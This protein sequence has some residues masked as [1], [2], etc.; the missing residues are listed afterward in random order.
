MSEVTSLRRNQQEE[1]QELQS[2]HARKKKKLIQSEEA[3]L[4]ELKDNYQQ[5]KEN[6]QTQGQAAV[7]HIRRGEEVQV[8]NLKEYYQ[9]R[10]EFTQNEGQAAVNHIKKN[11]DEEYQ[12][13]MANKEKIIQHTNTKMNEIEANY[14]KKLQDATAGREEKIN[15]VRIKV[16]KEIQESEEK[17]QKKLE[18]YRT[19]SVQEMAQKKEAYRNQS[20]Q[21]QQKAQ[22][23]LQNLDEQN[24]KAVQRELSQGK[25]AEEQARLVNEKNLTEITTTGEKEIQEEKKLLEDKQ[26]RLVSEFSQKQDKISKQWHQ[27]EINLNSEYANRIT[28]NKKANEEQIKKQYEHFKSTYGKNQKAQETSLQIQERNY[29][30]NLNEQKKDFLKASAKYNGKEEDPFY[31]VQD[32]G[33]RIFEDSGSYFIEAYLPEH[34]KDNVKIVVQKDKATVQGQR[35]FKDTFD[36][37]GKKVSTNSYQTFREE[38]SFDQPVITDGMTRE[39]DGDWVRISIPKMLNFEKKLDKKG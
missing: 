17:N 20:A 32:R 24:Q 15:Q 37:G 6:A 33:S 21:Y 27:R 16:N 18:T 10:K 7:N 19:E 22:K 3:K 26:K 4:D 31:K 25:K 13:A 39:R 29:V 12:K 30:K 1:L 11:Q 8:N 23:H 5:K 36:E 28:N 14:H 38:F 35:A 9:K 34:E 2:E